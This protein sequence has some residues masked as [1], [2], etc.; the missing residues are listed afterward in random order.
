MNKPRR[1]TSQA[2]STML[3]AR[4]VARTLATTL[5]SALLA[6]AGLC[7]SR[8]AFA[9][10]WLKDRQYSEGAG[11]RAGDF[12]FH[13]GIAAEG[14]YDSNWFLR[15]D[16][17][18]FVNSGVVG[19]PEMRITPSIS[20]AT[21]G[22][23]RAEGKTESAPSPIAFRAGLSGTYQEFF[24]ALTPEQRNMSVDANARLDIM[25]SR[26]FGASVFATYSRAIQPSVFGEPDLSFNYDRVSASAELSTQ[27]GGTAGTLDWHVGG[28][29][30]GTFFEDTGGQGYNNYSVGAY[31]RGRWKFRPRTA[32]IYDASFSYAAFNDV[33]AGAGVIAQLHN[34]DPIRAKIGINGLITP[35]FSL[36]AM[37]GYG[38]T[39]LV[40]PSDPTVKQYDSV[41]AQTELKFFLTAPPEAAGGGVSLS[42]STLALGYT[43]DFQT[44]YLADF[45]GFDRGYLKLSYFF[46]GRALLSLEGGVAAIEYPDL[47]LLSGKAVPSFTDTRIDTTL[48]SEYRFTSWLALTGTV[49]YT[50]N[51]S[52]ETLDVA[53][54]G[55]AAQTYALQWQKFEAYLGVRL[56]L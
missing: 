48:Y 46:A 26:P 43:R 21:V 24:G 10:E 6:I 50:T 5:G 47:T 22:T 53:G 37:V 44:S 29:Y 18:G 51:L 45:N 49:K 33:T 34:S 1:V 17:A 41:I 28:T 20:I 2:E 31:T 38:G 35:R 39:F 40:P 36:L 12:E 56:F 32:M 23:Q 3:E 16:K 4:R 54:M 13:P 14:G 30:S 11:V 25:P 7:A 15:T 19:T 27:P 42:Q 55:M 9:Q 8:P 52:N